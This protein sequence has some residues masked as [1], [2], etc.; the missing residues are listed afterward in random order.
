MFKRII[1]SYRRV[2]LRIFL[3]YAAF[4]WGICIIAT[5]AS[6]SVAFSFIEIIGGVDSSD[7]S[8]IPIYQYWLRMASSTFTLIGVGYL[9]LAIWTHKLRHLLPFAGLFM[10]VEGIILLY[11]ALK[12]EIPK[13]RGTLPMRAIK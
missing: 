5:L 2:L 3:F 11:F 6:P 1:N 4:G 13:T 9:T 12:L 10:M 8:T 7:I